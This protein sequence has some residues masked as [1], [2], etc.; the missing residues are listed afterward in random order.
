MK[1]MKE[2]ILLT[3]DGIVAS[4]G[5]NE[6]DVLALLMYAFMKVWDREKFSIDFD[7]A[8]IEILKVL[9]KCEVKEEPDETKS[10]LD[11]LAE[12]LGLDEDEEESED[13]EE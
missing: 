9:E 3:E 10:F 12:M 13:D 8:Q 5:M 6:N 4:K 11:V 7:K 2:L 1:K